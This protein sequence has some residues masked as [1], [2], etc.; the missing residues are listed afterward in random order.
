MKPLLESQDQEL[1]L[2]AQMVLKRIEEAHPDAPSVEATGPFDR[3]VG[4]LVTLK[5]TNADMKT[6]LDSIA[7]QTGNRALAL[8]E[9]W[10]GKPVT[11]DFDKT[12]YW[13]AIDE[14]CR[15]QSLIYEPDWRTGALKLVPVEAYV[16]VSSY[17]GPLVF[18]VSTASKNRTYR[19][20]RRYDRLTYNVYVFWED[21]LRPSWNEPVEVKKLTDQAG[22][23]IRLE[24]PDER[25]RSLRG[26]S[27]RFGR[28]E[29]MAVS[30]FQVRVPDYPEGLTKLS[31][32]SG[33]LTLAF[34]KGTQEIHIDDVLGGQGKSGRVGGYELKITETRRQR[35]YITLKTALTQDGKPVAWPNYG[36]DQRYGVWLVDLAGKKHRG[37]LSRGDVNMRAV[38]EQRER[39]R[40]QVQVVNAAK[41]D[42]GVGRMT[43]WG[44]NED[45][46][47]VGLLYVFPAEVKTKTYAFK[48]DNV[49]AP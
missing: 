37:Y 12:P 44:L 16:D 35:G 18:K 20:S 26:R 30:W 32:M 3:E 10:K 21:R 29:A 36:G 19:S 34:A 41:D 27:M 6:A 4:S 47:V 13:K 42:E 7:Q 46:D 24:P 9:D 8:P 40:V 15:Q 22:A 17:V 25:A 49:P 2:R 31:E 33:E 48:F 1:K 39:G 23:E 38:R 28:S 45:M 5:L 43:F 11:V 14:V